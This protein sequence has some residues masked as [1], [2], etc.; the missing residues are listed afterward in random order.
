MPISETNKCLLLTFGQYFLIL[1]YFN[2]II[3]RCKMRDLFVPIERRF[4]L[5]I[6]AL[7][8]IHIIFVFARNVVAK[9]ARNKLN[10]FHYIRNQTGLKLGSGNFRKGKRLERHLLTIISIKSFQRVRH[11]PLLTHRSTGGGEWRVWGWLSQPLDFW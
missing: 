8:D 1:Q 5:A 7:A 11:I 4:V 2:W 9:F 3:C 6:D 10:I